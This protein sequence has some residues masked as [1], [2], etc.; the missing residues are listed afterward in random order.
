MVKAPYAETTV[1]G[2]S[3]GSLVL[4]QALM[5]SVDGRLPD[6][7]SPDRAVLVGRVVWVA[8][9]AGLVRF[10]LDAIRP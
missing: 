5:E 8:T 6:G 9:D 3:Y 7:V 2:N 4:G 10:R 1:I